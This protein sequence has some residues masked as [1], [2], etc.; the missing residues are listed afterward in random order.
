MKWILRS[1]VIIHF[2]IMVYLYF[3]YIGY[4]YS[5]LWLFIILGI[6]RINA[7][8]KSKEKLDCGI[9]N[10]MLI[11]RIPIYRSIGK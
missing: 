11:V 4:W 9:S 3:T 5:I 7:F 10:H 2:I 1:I 8:T 6:F